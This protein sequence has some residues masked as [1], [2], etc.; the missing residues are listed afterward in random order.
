MSAFSEVAPN[1][2][3]NKCPSPDTWINKSGVISSEEYYSAI[4]NELLV[5]KIT[6]MNL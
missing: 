5:Y 3:K 1:W 2:K 4:N 6:W